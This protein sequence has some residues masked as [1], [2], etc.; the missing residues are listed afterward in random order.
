MAHAIA[1][2]ERRRV[3][4]LY[5]RAVIGDPR[6]LIENDVLTWG[7]TPSE[8]LERRMRELLADLPDVE[9]FLEAS[10]VTSVV[11]VHRRDRHGI[12]IV[13][14]SPALPFFCVL[15]EE[16]REIDG[17]LTI[18]QE[19]ARPEASSMR[20]VADRLSG[21]GVHEV[22]ADLCLADSP[23]V[24]AETGT[25][26]PYFELLFEWVPGTP[27]TPLPHGTHLA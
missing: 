26:I 23:Y 19:F 17:E 1:L 9:V 25:R 20:S 2:S 14:V 16:E 18:V 27:S 6:P 4:N 15:R 10:D 11:A 8:A 12:D 3:I 5:L 7:R 13:L 22:A 21:A 24:D